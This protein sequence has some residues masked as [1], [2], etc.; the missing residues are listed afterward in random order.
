MPMKKS[1]IVKMFAAVVFATLASIGLATAVP[2]AAGLWGISWLLLVAPGDL[3]RP[4]PRS[5][6]WWTFL[7]VGLLL[8]VL[9]TLPF[10]HLHLP[11]A[12]TQPARVAVAVPIWLFWLW[13]INRRWQREKG[14][15]AAV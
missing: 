15:V 12:P 9:L 6:R 14:N 5:E 10:L 8:A 4:I 1:F 2:G 7:L 11:P 3:T 13:A